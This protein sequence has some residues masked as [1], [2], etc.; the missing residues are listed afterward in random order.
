MSSRETPSATPPLKIEA[1]A[2]VTLKSTAAKKRN[3]AK[4]AVLR[5]HL[6]SFTRASVLRRGEGGIELD[7]P[8]RLRA[9]ASRVA[10]GIV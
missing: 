6:S 9:A 7:R 3:T 10:P 1:S 5:G 2:G 4:A 8:S